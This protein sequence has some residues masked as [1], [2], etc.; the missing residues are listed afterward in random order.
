[1]TEQNKDDS[2]VSL[3]QEEADI[4]ELLDYGARILHRAT[5]WVIHLKGYS[6]ALGGERAINSLTER[7]LL[8]KEKVT[9]AGREALKRLYPELPSPRW[10]REFQ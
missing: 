3:T 8:E 5:G 10:K 6:Y 4:L 7:G 9:E 2:Q 1:M